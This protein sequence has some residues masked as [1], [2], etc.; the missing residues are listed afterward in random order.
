MNFKLKAGAFAPIRAH[1]QDAGVDLL[2]PVTV[3]I[4]PGDSATID[5]GVCAE[6]P[7]GFCGQIWS[8]S[9]L[10][11]NHGILSTGMVDALYSG[12]IK[13][14]LYNHSHEIYTVNRGDKISQHMV[15]GWSSVNRRTRSKRRKIPRKLQI[16][17][18]GRG[19]NNHRRDRDNPLYGGSNGD[20]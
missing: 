10:N 19:T 1:K 9:G 18:D 2:S 11:I 17:R 6:I 4:Y 12:S 3:T 20:N 8:K 16:H 5:T 15:L 13:I 7:E 14:K